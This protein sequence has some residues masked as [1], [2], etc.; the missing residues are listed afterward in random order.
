[1]PPD[2]FSVPGPVTD[3]LV[4]ATP[5][6]SAKFVT[7]WLKPLRSRVAPTPLLRMPAVPVI[8]VE[9]VADVALTMTVPAPVSAIDPPPAPGSGRTKYP[10]ASN[11]SDAADTVPLIVTVPAG[12]P[13]SAWLSLPLQL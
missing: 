4:V 3:A 7:F 8:G 11:V 6:P 12:A 2:R 10:S 13:N 1:M 5:L 9:I